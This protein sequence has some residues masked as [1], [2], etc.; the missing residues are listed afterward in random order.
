[1]R[2]GELPASWEKALRDF[3]S[4]RAGTGQD[5]ALRFNLFAE[6]EFELVSDLGPEFAKNVPTRVLRQIE[7]EALGG[8]NK[9][10]TGSGRICTGK[11]HGARSPQP[12]AKIELVR[13]V[14]SLRYDRV[15]DRME[16]AS[17][18]AAVDEAIVTRVF[19]K[20]SRVHNVPEE[21][22]RGLTAEIVADTLA[23]T[24]RALAEARFA[25]L[26]LIETGIEPDAEKRDGIIQIVRE[27]PEFT[28]ESEGAENRAGL[29]VRRVNGLT[30]KASPDRADGLLQW[31]A[32]VLPAHHRWRLHARRAGNLHGDLRH[33]RGGQLLRMRRDAPCESQPK[34]NS[35][36]NAGHHRL[37]H[38]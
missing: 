13:A 16:E 11:G 24:L 28:F 19:A 31:A 15:L 38:T 5:R 37:R 29:V 4:E 36:H 22:S 33:G 3:D 8:R 21:F 1:M 6:R 20:Y 9:T 30:I 32:I 12:F 2:S 26:R 7:T 35:S 25:V 34:E 10:R 17:L 18:A 23:V 14:F 27:Q